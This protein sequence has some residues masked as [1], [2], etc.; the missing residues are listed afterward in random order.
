M[1]KIRYGSYISIHIA[2]ILKASRLDKRTEHMK[3]TNNKTPV[4]EALTTDGDAPAMIIYRGMQ[5]IR[6][7][8]AISFVTPLLSKTKYIITINNT[9]CD[10]EIANKCIRPNC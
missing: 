5:T 2:V 1:L 4:I 3:A 10:P 8:V 7:T 6:H 9:I